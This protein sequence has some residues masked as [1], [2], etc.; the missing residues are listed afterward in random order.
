MTRK[1]ITT[2]FASL[3]VLTALIQNTISAQRPISKLESQKIS[4]RGT[5]RNLATP[6]TFPGFLVS[7]VGFLSPAAA[8]VQDGPGVQ[9]VT[10]ATTITESGSYVLIHDIEIGSPGT[11]ILIA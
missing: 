11:A 2:M 8:F 3:L 1:T 4:S 6:V 10:R 7:S 5:I 9:P